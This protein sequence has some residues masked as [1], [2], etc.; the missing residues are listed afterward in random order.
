MC[1][2]L[3]ACRC[4]HVCACVCMHVY[5]CMWVSQHKYSPPCTPRCSGNEEPL[6]PSR[7]GM[8]AG[9]RTGDRAT[10]AGSQTL[11]STLPGPSSHELPI[12]PVSGVLG[13]QC[14]AGT[15]STLPRSPS[16][17]SVARARQDPTSPCKRWRR[18]SSLPPSLQPR[19]ST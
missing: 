16:L 9:Q 2:C 15:T 13:L 5:V 10:W 12:E 11:S 17:G 19:R 18:G 8:V 7:V 6:S 4:V 14:R 3:H 1:V